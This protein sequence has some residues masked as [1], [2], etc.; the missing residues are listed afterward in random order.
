MIFT[1]YSQHTPK[2]T[3]SSVCTAIKNYINSIKLCLKIQ[4]VYF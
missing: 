3:A 1:D 4:V 2:I